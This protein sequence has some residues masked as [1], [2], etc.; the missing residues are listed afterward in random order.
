MRVRLKTIAE[1]VQ[2]PIAKRTVLYRVAVEAL[3]NV[4]SHAQASRVEVSIKQLPDCICPK[5]KDDG[6][7]L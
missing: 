7:M 2:L 6:T 5:I 4:A 1:V 3:N